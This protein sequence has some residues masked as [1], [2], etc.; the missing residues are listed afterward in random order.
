MRAIAF[1]EFGGPEVLEI[2]ELLEPVPQGGEVVVRVVAASVNPTDVMMRAG[3]QTALMTY[4]KPPYI[5]GM[6][7]A[8]YVH[9]IGDASSALDVGQPVMGVVNPRRPQGGGHAQLVC[10]PAASLARLDKSVDL[11]AAAAV[12]MNGLTAK[13][14]LDFLDLPSKASLLV[15]GGAGV[16]G[17]YVIQLAKHA[18]LTVV[19]DAKESD[20][21]WL[22]RLG[23][24]EIAPRGAEMEA[25]ARA[26]FPAGVDGLVDA[27][28]LTDRAA[29]LVRTGGAAVSLRKSHPITDPRL[30]HSYLSVSD[31]VTN[32]KALLFLANLF[33]QGV[34]TPQIAMRLPMSEVAEAH[35][36]VAKG[37]LHGRIVLMMDR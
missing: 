24:D 35:R 17:G 3:Q 6:E 7:F 27:A 5:C 2:M 32:T 26:R 18:G 4:L 15:T 29:A 37:G 21:D 30:R 20:V 13:M 23:V 25:F 8:G 36:L 31:Q 11:S 22:R 9:S 14:A 33:R 12:P 28:L 1:N 19:A 16:V 10:V 34:L